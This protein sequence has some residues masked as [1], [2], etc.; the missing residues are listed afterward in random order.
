M[1]SQSIT[2]YGLVWTGV[3]F[4]AWASISFIVVPHN[5]K[6]RLL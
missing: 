2:S 6:F 1:I 5:E 4:P 3:Q